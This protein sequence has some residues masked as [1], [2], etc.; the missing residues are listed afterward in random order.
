MAKT[1]TKTETT[2]E[3]KPEPSLGTMVVV[4]GV[5]QS[6]ARKAD[7]SVGQHAR[8]QTLPAILPTDVIVP[9]VAHNPKRSGTKAHAMYE[10]ATQL[11]GYDAKNPSLTV[12]DYSA[13]MEKK[14]WKSYI[15]PEISWHLRAGFWGLKRG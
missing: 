2:P 4:K 15:R 9:L 7:D 5:I 6:P 8:R 3:T 13:A 11:K 14:G 12:A 10:F 1:K